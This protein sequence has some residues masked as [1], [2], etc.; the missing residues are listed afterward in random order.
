MVRYTPIG[1]GRVI[2][3]FDQNHWIVDFYYSKAARDNHAMGHPFMFGITV[4]GQFRWLDASVL[5]EMDYTGNTM[6]SRALYAPAEL[7]VEVQT[8][9]FVDVL[10]D[11]YVRLVTVRNV[12]GSRRRFSAF[13]HQNFYIYGNDI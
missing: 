10:D 3:A 4:D 6:V 8:K 5:R 12:T 7:G 9:D 11:V 2:V 13:M 1:N